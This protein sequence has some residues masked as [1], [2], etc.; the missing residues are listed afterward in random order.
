MYHVSGLKDGGV[1]LAATLANLLPTV[2][3]SKLL[4]SRSPGG[5][6]ETDR[7]KELPPA[8]AMPSRTR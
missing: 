2:Y 1:I 3:A 8:I 7:S 5:Y 6:L 4:M